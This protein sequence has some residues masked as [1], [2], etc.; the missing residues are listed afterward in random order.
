[1]KISPSDGGPG[2]AG[3]PIP[4]ALSSLSL[5]SFELK[6]YQNLWAK[7]QQALCIWS[8]AGCYVGFVGC[9]DALPAK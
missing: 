7:P 3:G 2:R 6:I 9:L 8:K 4:N 1:M 5:L